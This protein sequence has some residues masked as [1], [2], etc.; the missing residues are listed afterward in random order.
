MKFANITTW[1]QKAWTYLSEQENETGPASRHKHSSSSNEQTHMMMFVEHHLKGKELNST[2]THLKKRGWR[3]EVCP[4]TPTGNGGTH[5]GTMAL[6]RANIQYKPLTN[7]SSRIQGDQWIGLLVRFAGRDL[8]IIT[9]Y[10]WHNIGFTGENLKILRQLAE[11]VGI[12]KVEFMIVADWNIPAQD[13]RASC[14]PAFVRGTVVTP[15]GIEHTC[16]S[17][18]GRMLDYMIVSNSL[19]GQ[20]KLTADFE[21]PWR[22]HMGLSIDIPFDALTT[23]VLAIA[24]PQHLEY[25]HGPRQ[26][27][28]KEHLE[29]ARCQMEYKS[30]QPEYDV[31]EE[32]TNNDLTSK[33]A[34]FSRAA[35]TWIQGYTSP[36][37]GKK[38]M[39][40]ELLHQVWRPAAKPNRVAC[41]YKSP[42][43]TLWSSICA[44]LQ[45]ALC[46]KRKRQRSTNLD[47]L[48][49]WIVK[50]ADRVHRHHDPEVH[51]HHIVHKLRQVE[52]M[53]V[54][55]LQDL[56][57]KVQD[58]ILKANF[59]VQ[60][61]VS[62]S[63]HDW[64]TEALQ[65][66]AGT[67]HRWTNAQARPTEPD[68]EFTMD[69]V[70]YTDPIEAMNARCQYWNQLWQ[71]TP[72]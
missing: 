8:L 3:S 70:I 29:R 48:V 51:D 36:M 10:L 39:R 31:F 41:W 46:L 64:M 12:H 24:R 35:E 61:N 15:P 38:P 52:G 54:P 25:M 72:L 62:K 67:A 45:D 13:M 21:S 55:Q 53:M 65:R 2:R 57:G 18:P 40:G 17:G 9:A 47:R 49:D 14:W 34:A 63:F 27:T 1:G 60:R 4:A 26:E 56:I 43:A 19:V 44:R 33:Y 59:Q 42:A 69:T 20:T 30:I 68:I 32:A 58:F 37:V 28:W 7:G 11:V 6:I 16:S 5:G 66:G 23:Q 71:P 50:A 22:P